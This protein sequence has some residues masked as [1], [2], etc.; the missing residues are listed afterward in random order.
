M[1]SSNLDHPAK[2]E[3]VEIL[4]N[5]EDITGLFVSIELFENIFIGGVTGS[6]IIFDSD[7]QNFIEK[8]EIEFIEDI[9]FTFK[10]INGVELKF[11]GV[12]NGLRN[13]LV[14]NQKKM[15]VIDFT[16]KA[17][18]Q[19]E[20]VSINKA[21]RDVQPNEI[22]REM[23]EG[24]SEK[25]LESTFIESSFSSTSEGMTWVAGNRKPIDVIRYVLNHAIAKEGDPQYNENEATSSGTSGYLCWE[26]LDGYRFSS[27]ENL[28]K[29]GNFTETHKN[30]ANYLANTPAGKEVKTKTIMVYDFPKVGDYFEKLRSGAVKSNHVSFD[31]DKGIYTNFNYEATTKE[32]T[33]KVL[34][35]T[36]ATTRTVVKMFANEKFNNT[37]KK[38]LRDKGDQSRMYLSQTITKQNTFSD[39]HGRITLPAQYNI[40][41][42]DLIEIEIYKLQLGGTDLEPQKKHSGKYLI[43]QVG[44]HFLRNGY[45][46]TKLA[47]IRTN[48]EQTQ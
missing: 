20:M 30:Y 5:G 38:E 44:H 1:T 34:E 12:M 45:S 8:N 43:S 19:N 35:N 23:V 16:S 39:T 37:C 21:F 2:V 24:D 47:L 41:A 33:E 40:R 9:S 25:G 3:M 14:K 10:N 7:S 27:M 15:Y 13:E 4:I 22:I 42:G 32:V 17:V 18:R 11:E 48:T 26:T 31:L 6:I 46:Y 29:E 28:S 36:K